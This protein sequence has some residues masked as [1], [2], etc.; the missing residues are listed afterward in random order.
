MSEPT[1]QELQNHLGS[2]LQGKSFL[3]EFRDWFDAETWGLAEGP[4]TVVS[5]VAGQIELHLAEFTIGHLTEEELRVQLQPLALVRA[6]SH[7]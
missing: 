3:S 4:D 5:Q 1:L 2:Y 7:R 6:G